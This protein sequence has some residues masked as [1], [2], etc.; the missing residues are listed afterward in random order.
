VNV[1]LTSDQAQTLLDLVNDEITNRDEYVA[2]RSLTRSWSG[3]YEPGPDET[4]ARREADE[5]RA[6]RDELTK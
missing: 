3:K 5:L 1:T 6:I 4:Q 2:S